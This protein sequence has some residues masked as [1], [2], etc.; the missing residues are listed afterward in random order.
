MADDAPE[1]W[2]VPQRPAMIAAAVVPAALLALVALAGWAYEREIAPRR[3]APIT[4]FPAP[5]I[6]TF[7]HD[8]A[9]D[10]P[11]PEPR[12]AADPRL[13]AAKRAV[14]AGGWPR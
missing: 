9:G 4:T 7:V 8:G 11:R 3:H 6:E 10:P 5:G 1:G 13:A 12:R 14:A 2:R